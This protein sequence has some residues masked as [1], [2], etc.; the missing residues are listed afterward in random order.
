M[1]AANVLTFCFRGCLAN[2]VQFNE[3]AEVKCPY[4]DA[5]YA[6][7]SVLQEREIKAVSKNGEDEGMLAPIESGVP[8]QGR[9]LSFQVNLRMDEV[10]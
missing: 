8:M 5:N 3:E 4:R 10:G 6:C 7:D 9:F 2:T 1:V